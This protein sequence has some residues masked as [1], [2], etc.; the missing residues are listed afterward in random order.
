MIDINFFTSSN[1]YVSIP[2]KNNPKLL[3]AIDNNQIAS[4]S[5]NLYNPFSKNGKFFKF[6]LNF[7]FSKLNIFSRVLYKTNLYEK[8]KFINFLEK[9][10]NQNLISSIYLATDRDKVVLQLQD[11][12]YRVIAYLKYPITNTGIEHIKNEKNAMDIL[13]KEY[14]LYSTFNEIPFIILKP[15]NGIIDN[16]SSSKLK[17]ILSDFSRGRNSKYS[18]SE[19]P[20]INSILGSLKEDINLKEYLDV[21]NS[22]INISRQKYNLVYEHGDFTPWN[23]IKNKEEYTIF[24][25]EYFIEDGIEYFDLIKYHY[26]VG[27][28]LNKL[29]NVDLID[30]ILSQIDNNILNILQ[31]FL[32]KEIILKSINNSSY[33]FEKKLLHILG[34]KYAKN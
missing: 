17:N 5:F 29:D 27:K 13:S 33:L 19:H 26:M 10:L 31:L 34:T 15:L 1:R 20:R 14:L 28:L 9:K 30:Y 18:L 21:T 8:S 23:I 4:N 32:I 16:I 3:L 25:F 11:K 22:I 2:T 6:F 7:L 12:K 24:D